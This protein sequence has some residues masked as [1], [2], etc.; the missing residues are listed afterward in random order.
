M[1][2]ADVSQ[3]ASDD[4]STLSQLEAI[5]DTLLNEY[6]TLQH[7][8]RQLECHCAALAESEQN[9]RDKQQSVHDALSKTVAKLKAISNIPEQ[10]LKVTVAVTEQPPVTETVTSPVVATEEA[11]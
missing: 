8:Y 1:F 11:L 2:Q 3:L 10:E 5:I 9:L 6:A 7:Q 4:M